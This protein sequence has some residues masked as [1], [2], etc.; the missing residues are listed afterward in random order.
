[1]VFYHTKNVYYSKPYCSEDPVKRTNIVQYNIYVPFSLLQQ[2]TFGRDIGSSI[3][4]RQ[5]DL[6]TEQTDVV[7]VCRSSRTLR[8]SI[9]KAGGDL[10]ENLFHTE[11]NKNLIDPVI[12]V[13]AAG[14]IS[15][16]RVYFLAWEPPADVNMFRQSVSTFISN[17]MNKAA[18]ENC[19]SI[20]FP[21][22]GCNGYGC[23]ISLIAQTMIEEVH[24]QL[25]TYPM[26]V[27]FVILS[28]RTDIY[29]EFQKK[30]S[31]V[32]SFPKTKAISARIGKGI[33]EVQMGDITKQ[34]ID[35]IIGS[36]S[37][38][39]LKKAIMKAAGRNIR[40]AYRE[41]CQKNPNSLI[42]SLP[43]GQ[44]S[45]K[46]IFFVKWEPDPNEEFLRQSLVDFIWTV[47]QNIISYKFTS[48][49]F[50]AIG[51]GEHRCPV[52]LVVKTMVKEIKNQLKMRNI[53]LT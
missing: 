22:I 50:P 51:C 42:V 40:T 5:G 25:T 26:S 13:A 31:S 30:I 37:S 38:G 33:V 8:E 32:Q 3:C 14:Q 7:V 53:P 47:I 12:S 27:A 15:A 1:M 48:V 4:I 20:A 44:L 34:K 16:K 17:A 52:D 21:A 19:R 6:I 10:M 35:V 9:L 39:I 41:Q 18:S 49:A 2:T 23:S 28:D 11:V 46:Q 36:S 43:S 24:H 29:E 45:C